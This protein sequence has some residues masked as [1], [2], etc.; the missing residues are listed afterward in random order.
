[1]KGARPRLRHTF[2]CLERR[3]TCRDEIR[4]ELPATADFKEQTLNTS[5]IGGKFGMLIR[6]SVLHRPEKVDGHPPRTSIC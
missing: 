5:V 6:G 4:I 3:I 1:M 2:P